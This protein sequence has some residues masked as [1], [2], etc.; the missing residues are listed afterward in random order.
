MKVFKVILLIVGIILLLATEAK[1]AT[2]N[3]IGL[4]LVIISTYKLKVLTL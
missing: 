4:V 1:T 3:L 2:P